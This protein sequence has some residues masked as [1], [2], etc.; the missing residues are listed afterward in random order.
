MQMTSVAA[1]KVGFPPLLAVR[2]PNIIFG[3]IALILYKRA[4]K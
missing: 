4:P 3:I 1:I 2:L